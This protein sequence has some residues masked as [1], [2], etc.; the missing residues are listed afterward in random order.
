MFVQM[1]GQEATEATE[2]NAGNRAI[3]SV[4]LEPKCAVLCKVVVTA[5]SSESCSTL[6]WTD[7]RDVYV[8]NKS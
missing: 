5:G 7:L 6:A 8:E 2:T 1:S 3:C 4:L